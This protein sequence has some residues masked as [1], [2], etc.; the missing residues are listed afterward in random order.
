MALTS[1]ALRGTCIS[2]SLPNIYIE[3]VLEATVSFCSSHFLILGGKKKKKEQA[4]VANRKRT[5]W[6]ERL[7]DVAERDVWEHLEDETI[8]SIPLWTTCPAC[9]ALPV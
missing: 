2:I 4:L 8:G 1:K 5:P 9:L 7:L 3:Q 6:G